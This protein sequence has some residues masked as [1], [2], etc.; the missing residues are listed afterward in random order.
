MLEMPVEIAVRC[1]G[2]RC[3]QQRQRD[4]NLREAGGINYDDVEGEFRRLAASLE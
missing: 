2:E 4:A 3:A 1:R